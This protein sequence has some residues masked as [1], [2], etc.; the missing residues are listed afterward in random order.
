MLPSTGQ[1]TAPHC[2]GQ[3]L[4]YAP[5]APCRACCPA[6]AARLSAAPSS[7]AGCSGATSRAASYAA[8][9]SAKPPSAMWMAP[10]CRL[11]WGGWLACG[12]HSSLAILQPPLQAT[13]CQRLKTP[14]TPPLPL[15]PPTAT[16]LAPPSHLDACVG[17][18]RLQLQRSRVCLE[19]R[20][21]ATQVLVAGGQPLPGG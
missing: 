16:P 7:A 1:C 15:H 9:A 14:A 12:F 4:P 8:V 17:P 19:G 18:P 5:R 10:D 21:E 11:W 20:G 13:R 2:C 3:Q 6:A